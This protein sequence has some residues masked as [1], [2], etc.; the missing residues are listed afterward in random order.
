MGCV[1]HVGNH[2][3]ILTRKSSFNYKI[4][5]LNTSYHLHHKA[6]TWVLL[7]FLLFHPLVD[8]QVPKALKG[9]TGLWWAIES[10]LNSTSTWSR[11]ECIR[12]LMFQAWKNCSLEIKVCCIKPVLLCTPEHFIRPFSP[13]PLFYPSDLI[14]TYCCICTSRLFVDPFDYDFLSLTSTISAFLSP[15]SVIFFSFLLH[16]ISIYSL[17]SLPLCLSYR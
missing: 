16:C 8:Q 17:N 10:H 13:F 14:P 5:H 2:C 15:F 3:S 12:A 4:E 1:P 9:E 6:V 11:P 7:L